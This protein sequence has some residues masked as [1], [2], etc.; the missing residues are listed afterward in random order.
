MKKLLPL[1]LC[2]S[3]SFFTVARATKSVHTLAAGAKTVQNSTG[4]KADAET[5]LNDANKALAAMIKAAR[6][7]KSL[8]SDTAK[9]KPFWK[10]YG[11]Y[12]SFDMSDAEQE[13]VA[14]EADSDE[15]VASADNDNMEDAS[16]DEGKEMSDDDG[17]AGD[18]GGE[19][20]SDDDGS[21]DEGE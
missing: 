20:I 1:L 11:E 6:A 3:L 10:S 2:L 12:E 4:H 17:R 8:D 21:G 7:D 9:N 14:A 18:S 15:E 19:D 5:L 13:E 16:D